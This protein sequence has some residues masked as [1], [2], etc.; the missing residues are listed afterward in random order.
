M[1]TQELYNLVPAICIIIAALLVIKFFTLSQTQ[2]WRDF[3]ETGSKFKAI[4]PLT[5]EAAL[6]VVLMTTAI[7]TQTPA[8]TKE[9]L[10]QQASDTN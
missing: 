1:N 6:I 7:I 9:S 3:A 2:A 8:D 4:L 5:M 10:P